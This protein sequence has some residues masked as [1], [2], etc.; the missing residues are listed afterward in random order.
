MLG[1][2]LMKRAIPPVGALVRATRRFDSR[3][4]RRLASVDRQV[5]YAAVAVMDETVLLE[6][7]APPQALRAR[8]QRGPSDIQAS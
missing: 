8:S 4:A 3:L 5:L 7:T 2:T 1:A 6:R